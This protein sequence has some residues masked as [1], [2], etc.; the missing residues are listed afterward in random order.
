V[1]FSWNFDTV[2]WYT[3]LIHCEILRRLIQSD[4][5]KCQNE[6]KWATEIPTRL[7]K[8]QWRIK[9][10]QY[11]AVTYNKVQGETKSRVV[12]VLATPSGSKLGNLTVEKFFVGIS[13]VR[14][15]DHLRIMPCNR[16]ELEYL[17][18]V[19]LESSN[20]ILVQQLRCECYEWLT[21]SAMALGLR[22]KVH[23]SIYWTPVQ[24]KIL[25]KKAQNNTVH[26]KEYQA[27]AK[28]LGVPFSNKKIVELEVDLGYID[29]SGAF[30]TITEKMRGRGGGR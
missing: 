30:T 12:L 6:G 23:P 27:L 18:K 1:W 3:F 28:S 4:F 16:F 7:R 14:H 17:K 29:T 9:I 15:A 10:T 24:K 5:E 2:F 13:R 8:H 20:A 26:I 19:V 11:F 22:E 21:E 25:L